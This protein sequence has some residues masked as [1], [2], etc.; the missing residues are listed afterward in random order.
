VEGAALG[1]VGVVTGLVVG[2]IVRMILI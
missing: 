1:A 2:G